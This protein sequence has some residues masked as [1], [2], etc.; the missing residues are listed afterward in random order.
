MTKLRISDNISLEPVFQHNINIKK[1][2]KNTI[3]NG[4]P[5]VFSAATDSENLVLLIEIK[6]NSFRSMAS[7][8]HYCNSP[9]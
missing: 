7:L 3:L 6:D 8:L 2:K 5:A 1:G 9:V 4:F